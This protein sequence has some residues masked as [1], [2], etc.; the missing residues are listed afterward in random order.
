VESSEQQIPA[1]EMERMMK[2][3]DSEGSSREAEVVGSCRDYGCDG[4]YDAALAG[5]A[6]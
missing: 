2:A 4:P 1:A 5:A 3:Q 6:E